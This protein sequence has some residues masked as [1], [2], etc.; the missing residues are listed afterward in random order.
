MAPHPVP[1]GLCLRAWLWE[2]PQASPPLAA[3]PSTYPH[4]T[5]IHRH[6]QIPRCR[7]G[8]SG[9]PHWFLQ[10]QDSPQEPWATG[11][12]FLPGERPPGKRV[13]FSSRPGP[14]PPGAG[15]HGSVQ[16]GARVPGSPPLRGWWDSSPQTPDLAAFKPQSGSI[17]PASFL[18]SR[19]V[20]GPVLSPGVFFPGWK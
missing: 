14:A 8:L 17:W 1:P 19:G 5:Q 7:E 4:D 3:L 6:P 15:P 2:S 18:F 10:P 20:S 13:P 9:P 16:T 11:D 12:G